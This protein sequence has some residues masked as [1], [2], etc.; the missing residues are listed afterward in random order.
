MYKQS[1]PCQLRQFKV[2]LIQNPLIRKCKRCD[3]SRE[4]HDVAQV[5]IRLV[6][7]RRE[8]IGVTHRRT[9]SRSNV[10]CIYHMSQLSQYVTVVTNSALHM[11]G[12]RVARAA[13]DA[14]RHCPTLACPRVQIM[15]VHLYSPSLLDTQRGPTAG[16][17]WI[18][19]LF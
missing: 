10:W 16:M 6:R 7:H 13:C 17:L 18:L 4:Q 2:T 5:Y 9:L 19:I 11:S 14:A 12:G 1:H 8:W 3:L 15:G